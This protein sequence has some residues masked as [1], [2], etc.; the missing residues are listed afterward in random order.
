M[1]SKP[2]LTFFD[3]TVKVYYTVHRNVSNSINHIEIWSFKKL[4]K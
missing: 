4:K 2:F 1:K 3:Q